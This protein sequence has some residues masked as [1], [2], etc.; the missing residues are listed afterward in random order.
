LSPISCV[1]L[2]RFKARAGILRAARVRVNGRG[3]P[4]VAQF[5]PRNV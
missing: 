3:L 5:E 2:Q 4:V 1:L